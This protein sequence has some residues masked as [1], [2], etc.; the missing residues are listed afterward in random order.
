MELAPKDSLSNDD[1]S[2]SDE[3]EA[4]KQEG[5]K[6]FPQVPER[7]SVSNNGKGN[8][9]PVWLRHTSNLQRPEHCTI[10]LGSTPH[11]GAVP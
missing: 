4:G 9:E 8:C 5:R 2:K 6:K 10:S 3:G 7:T 1:G 11:G